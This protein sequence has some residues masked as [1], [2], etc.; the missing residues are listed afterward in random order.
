[1]DHRLRDATKELMN[2]DSLVLFWNTIECL[3]YN[4]A[5]EGIHAQHQSV[6][7]DGLSYLDDLLLGAMLEASLD[8]EVSES[9]HHECNGLLDNSINYFELLICS[10]NFELLLK[11]YR[12][13]LVVVGD[14]FVDDVLPVATHVTVKQFSIVHRLSRRGVAVQDLTACLFQFSNCDRWLDSCI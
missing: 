9:I 3:L 11:K 8:Q 6:A 10:A 14:D 2:H 1:M 13:L 7:T 5:T 4:M 12:S